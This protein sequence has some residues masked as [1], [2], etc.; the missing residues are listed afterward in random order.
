MYKDKYEHNEL[1]LEK[2]RRETIEKDELMHT[3]K[4]D[5]EN[6]RTSFQSGLVAERENDHEFI[7][8]IKCL[9]D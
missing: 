3:L 8:K 7:D 1:E 5:N 4:Q 9:E 2:L 6:M